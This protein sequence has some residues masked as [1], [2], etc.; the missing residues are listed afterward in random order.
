MSPGYPVVHPCIIPYVYIYIYWLFVIQTSWLSY[1]SHVLFRTPF[2]CSLIVTQ[3]SYRYQLV[4]QWLIH[5]LFCA[6]ASL[7]IG[8]S[9]HRQVADIIWYPTTHNMSCFVHSE[10][11]WLL[12][13]WAA[14]IIWLSMD[15]LFHTFILSGCFTNKQMSFDHPVVY[16]C[17]T[18]Y[19]LYNSAFMHCL[20]PS[21]LSTNNLI[22]NFPPQIFCF[23]GM[24]S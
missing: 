6:C 15:L 9:L 2:M 10:I 13:R 5:V 20:C 14:N 4:I 24:R 18:S 23:T 11:A 7:H 8:I 12:H 16:P 17:V 22:W 19:I 21:C 3:M 1:C